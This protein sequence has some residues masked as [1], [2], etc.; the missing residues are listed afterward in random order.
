MRSKQ[1]KRKAVKPLTEAEKLLLAQCE[2]GIQRSMESDP[3]LLVF[4]SVG[5]RALRKIPKVP[6]ATVARLREFVAGSKARNEPA[7]NDIM[8]IGGMTWESE[9]FLV[10]KHDELVRRWP[11][12]DQWKLA[13]ALVDI[14]AA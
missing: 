3:E 10:D 6:A 13:Q 7:L 2:A 14:I 1:A 5:D 8:F 12:V 4:M 11:K 9:R